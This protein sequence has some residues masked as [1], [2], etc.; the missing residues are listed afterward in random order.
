MKASPLT[1]VKEKFES[2]EKLIEAVKG[3]TDGD[4]WIDRVDEDKGLDRV[5]NKKLLRLHAVLTEV[6]SQFGTRAKLIEAITTLEKR[7]DAGYADRLSRWSTPRLM[8][9]YRGAKK[10][11][12]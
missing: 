6:K 11:N 4:L 1:Q 2:K 12:R 9:W 7:K 3:L 10:R 8:D 5:S